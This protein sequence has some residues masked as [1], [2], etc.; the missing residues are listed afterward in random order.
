MCCKCDE[1]LLCI[2]K[3]L[4][5][6][7]GLNWGLVGL[8]LL[9]YNVSSWN[10]VYMLFGGYS[11]LEALIYIAVGIAAL[12]HLWKMFGPADFK[13]EKKPAGRRRRR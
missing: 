9:L 1:N 13:M 2:C 3:L 6:I 12:C 8:G 11:W 10:V 4:L 5:I 7:G